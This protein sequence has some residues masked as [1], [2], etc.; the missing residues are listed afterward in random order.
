MMDPVR[1]SAL[2]KVI[3]DRYGLTL[4]ETSQAEI[5]SIVHHRIAELKLHSFSDYLSLISD[6]HPAEELDY[7]V[8]R[9]TVGETSFFR[10]PPQFWALR[11][12]VLP[13]LLKEKQ[14][15]KR[16]KIRI[17]SAGCA[18][19]EEPY[20]LAMIAREKIGPEA[21]LKIEIVACDVNKKYLEQAKQGIYSAKDLRNIDDYLSAKYFEK[22][23]AGF[24]I[25]EELRNLVE[26]L[27]FNLAAGGYDLLAQAGIFD[28]IFCRNVLIYFE[29]GAF[30]QAIDNF[31]RI[32]EMTGHLFLGY[33]ESLYGLDSKFEGIYVPE[34]FYYRKIPGAKKPITHS[35]TAAKIK[36][37]P[38]RPVLK[39]SP[40]RH[41]PAMV[42][43]AE[44]PAKKPIPA[45]VSPEQLWEKGYQAM[46]DEQYEPARDCFEKLVEA[47][48]CSPMGYLGVAF[49]LANQGEDELSENYLKISFEKDGLIPEGYYLLGLLAER[50]EKW[51]K[52]I[53]NYQRAIFLK[54]DFTIAHFNL[55]SLYLRLSELKNAERE[56]KVVI[57]LLKHGPER[58]YL[59]GV[60]TRR[61]LVDWAELHLKKT[62]ELRK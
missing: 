53:E 34:A 11:D 12:F 47:A 7:L 39:I 17:L 2:Q 52:A 27:H 40:P 16:R 56:L 48:P 25:K 59:S 44:A 20:S 24:Q 1:V 31:Y 37:L 18:S 14:A 54:S 43:P 8:S 13:Q 15:K 35:G 32:L 42:K 21:Q 60:W 19:G 28:I 6:H 58:V 29:P 55:A 61:A 9:I 46:E 4:K 3:R 22:I 33:S 49:I 36:S 23:G 10:T 30:Y 26:F 38:A 62:Q 5:K 57:G 50:K 45:M 51:E 41:Q